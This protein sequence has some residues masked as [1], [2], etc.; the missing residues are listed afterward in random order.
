MGA[1]NVVKKFTFYPD[2]ASE[3]KNFFDWNVTQYFVRISCLAV[4]KEFF[5]KM[6]WLTY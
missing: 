1:L 3:H 4:K 2:E 6:S 5:L